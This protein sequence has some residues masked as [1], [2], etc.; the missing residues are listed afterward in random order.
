ML[1]QIYYKEINQSMKE[2]RQTLLMPFSFLVF[3]VQYSFCCPTAHAGQGNVFFYPIYQST[4]F[5]TIHITGTWFWVYAIFIITPEFL[6]NKF[7]NQ[8]YGYNLVVGSSMYTYVSH[9]M[10][11][12][13]ITRL[14]M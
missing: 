6:N 13:I 14:F 10:W 8:W 1:D 2:L 3:F 4:E 5:Q 9:Y 11:M 12:M 7:G